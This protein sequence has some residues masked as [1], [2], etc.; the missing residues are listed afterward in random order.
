MIRIFAA[1]FF[2]S[3][4]FICFGAVFFAFPDFLG[5]PSRVLSA[6]E[7]TDII[8]LIDIK[9]KDIC[10]VSFYR[11]FIKIN[12]PRQSRSV[13]ID[14]ASIQF[15]NYSDSS[16]RKRD[17]AL[18]SRIG[19]AGLLFTKVEQNHV[20]SIIYNDEFGDRQSALLTFDDKQYVL[21]MKGML[22]DI[23]EVQ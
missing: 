5:M 17:W 4:G 14:N 3:L 15:W 20:F 1:N 18:A 19:V 6:E 12:F 7:F 23:N 8:C 10:N 9:T 13:K 21:P 11:R 2:W 22:S 16:L